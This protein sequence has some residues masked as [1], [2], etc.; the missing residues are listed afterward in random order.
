MRQHFGAISRQPEGNGRLRADERRQDITQS[1]SRRKRPSRPRACRRIEWF[2]L[3]RATFCQELINIDAGEI[4]NSF[5]RLL[6]SS[7]L[8]RMLLYLVRQSFSST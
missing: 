6:F 3:R 7:Q 2:Y 5:D 1:S 8:L 4:E